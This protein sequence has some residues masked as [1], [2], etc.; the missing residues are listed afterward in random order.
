[1][2]DF[3]LSP[4]MHRC[5]Y[6]GQTQVTDMDDTNHCTVTATAYALNILWSEAQALLASMGRKRKRGFS[7][8]KI[9]GHNLVKPYGE[10]REAKWLYNEGGAYA[11]IRAGMTVRTFLRKCDKG[12]RYLIT[13]S[14][15]AMAVV[16]G[17]LC[18]S[19]SNLGRRVKYAF[20]VT[21]HLQRPGAIN[22]P[23]IVNKNLTSVVACEK[24]TA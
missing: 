24:V 19:G 10:V 3:L 16:D 23:A 4:Y 5:Y 9:A 7:T 1:M 15:H 21:P 17:R 14:G 13:V 11:G 20:E 18:D 2:S 8:W 12:K 6:S 22:L